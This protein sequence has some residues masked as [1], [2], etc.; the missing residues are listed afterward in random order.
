VAWLS[1]GPPL[2]AAPPHQLLIEAEEFRVVEGPWRV[3]GQDEAYYAATFSNTFI[4]RQKLLGAP[5]RAARA[6]AT[7][8]ARI[9]AAGAYRVWSRYENP[10]RWS[11]EHTVRIEQGGNVVFERTYGR[12]SSPKL[13]PF[14]QGLKPM[15]EFSWGSGDNVVWEPA[16]E[17]VNLRAGPARLTLLAGRQAEEAMP[18]GGAAERH[19]DCLLLTTDA[20][21]GVDDGPP[22]MW[23]RLDR[24]LNQDGQA[25]L[26]VTN[27]APQARSFALAVFTHSPYWQPRGPLPPAI[28]LLAPGQASGFVAVGQALDTTNMQELTVTALGA[29]GKAAVASPFVVELA[30]DPAGRRILRRVEHR[31][32]GP[33]VMTLEIPHELRGPHPVV[34]TIEEWHEDLLAYLR[35]LPPRGPPPREIPVFGIM[36]SELWGRREVVEPLE[37]QH[38][39]A[40]TGLLLG[41]NTWRRGSIPADLVERYR[42]EFRDNLLDDVRDVPTSQLRQ[43]MLDQKAK[44][45]FDQVSLISFGDEIAVGDLDPKS[46]E[47][48]EAFRRYLAARQAPLD[49]ATALTLEVTGGRAYYWSRQFGVDRAI[50]EMAART[51]IV[52]EVLGKQVRTGANYA[53]H[54]DYFPLS[55]P[56][57]RMFRHHGMTMPWS[58]DYVFQVPEASPLVSGYLCDVMRAAARRDDLPVYYYNMPHFPGQTPRDF[59]LSVYSALGHGNRVLDFFAG[60]PIYDYTENWV[61][62]DA[63]DTWRA[64]RD[65]VADVG[66][67]DDLLARGRTRPAEMAMVVSD[68]DDLW[69]SARGSSI[70]NFERKNLYHL[71]RHAQVPVDF[72]GDED[73]GEPDLLGRYKVIVLVAGHLAR[74]SAL[75]LAR[76]VRAGGHLLA[77]AASGLVD[78][79][80]SELL[81]LREV[82]GVAAVETQIA[83]RTCSAKECLAWL[84]PLAELPAVGRTVPALAV[85]ERPVPAGAEVRATFSDGSPAILSHSFGKGRA[86]RL[87]FFPGTAYLQPAFPRRPYQRGT[88]DEAFNHFLPTAF[89]QA[90]A[91]LVLAELRDAGVTPPV[92]AGTDG[93]RALALHPEDPPP[94]LDVAVVDAPTGAAVV[95][96]NYSGAPLPRLTVTLRA[97]GPFRRV[98]AARAGAL[99]TS[100]DGETITVTLPLDWADIVMF[101]R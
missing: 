75:A 83:E 3:L 67:A 19:I 21:A 69:E 56:W 36:G 35:A 9:P 57:L 55:G 32:A 16:P 44:G 29:D 74:G 51:R 7:Y 93:A 84:R 99:P 8:T 10:S 33:A 40:E 17:L 82:F 87:C 61:A 89:N 71:L 27:T 91:R 38:A 23:H 92:V 41:R 42:P 46:A 20:H 68:A 98:Y 58:E 22:P 37:L 97:R 1:F 24:V 14:E 15:A 52:E 6:R 18:R 101:R 79:Y 5:A 62:W 54:P 28:A 49:P 88:T 94:P 47:Q 11:V 4:S 13:W 39:R 25:F 53:P 65:V 76:W 90:A 66:Q 73:L 85:V 72:L 96:A 100:A 70:F 2:L 31:Y 77:V 95:I 59:T 34:R 81:Q 80:E 64:I 30:A 86:T 78:E 45:R 48:N 43:W 50:E 12:T 63:H 26:R 60:L